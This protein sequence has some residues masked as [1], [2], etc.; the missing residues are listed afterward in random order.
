MLEK[1]EVQMSLRFWSV[2]LRRWQHNLGAIQ[3]WWS[4]LITENNKADLTSPLTHLFHEQTL[5]LCVP[6]TYQTQNH[7]GLEELI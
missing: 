4:P 3:P 5:V 1:R 6:S 7:M 2:D